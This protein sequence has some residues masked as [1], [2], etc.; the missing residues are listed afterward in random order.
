[1]S[2]WSAFTVLPVFSL[3]SSGLLEHYEDEVETVLV[4]KVQVRIL[5]PSP[6]IHASAND[7]A[8]TFGFNETYI[9]RID[10]LVL[11]ATNHRIVF[12]R[13]SKGFSKEARGIGLRRI[14]GSLKALPVGFTASM[15]K[16][17]KVEI[18]TEMFGKVVIVFQDY[19]A[20]D[21]VLQKLELSLKRKAWERSTVRT[22]KNVTPPSGVGVA[23]IIARN[24][25]RNEEAR[26][27]SRSAFGEYEGLLSQAKEVQAVIHKY[28]ATLDKQNNKQ[29]NVN[30]DEARLTDMLRGMGIT[31]AVT[32]KAA[33]SMYH[34]QLARQLA[35][36]LQRGTL[37]QNGGIMT[38]VDVFCLY[39][40]ALGTNLVS[41]DDM[42]TAA[43]M[44][45]F[46][47]L[48]MSMREFQSGVL[49]IQ[50]DEH[51][52][53]LMAKKLSA[54]AEEKG[55]ITAIH[56]GLCFK[57]NTI[58]ATEMLHAAEAME[59]LCRDKTLE[60]TIFYT[61]RFATMSW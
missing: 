54:L 32:K 22:K 52:D 6:M 12:L 30:E 61:N 50:A 4:P 37:A 45:G 51:D 36:F 53:E 26:K 8:N 43:N 14:R 56:A 28:S 9:D 29:S 5:T 24:R 41:A 18:M 33:G 19:Q 46:H 57:I 11:I 47:N 42:F 35:D 1:M 2:N 21:D 60:S 44:I 15:Y 25:Q 23:A 10:D 55:G 38:L 17:P 3:S 40:R 58:L 31:N 16:S 59:Y 27:L 49:V 7:S 13:D 48:G 39:N 34:Q 20:R